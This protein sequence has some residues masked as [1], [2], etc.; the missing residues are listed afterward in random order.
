[1]SRGSRLAG[2]GRNPQQTA[3]GGNGP[4]SRGNPVFPPCPAH[5]REDEVGHTPEK[6]RTRSV[7]LVFRREFFLDPE[8][9][10]GTAVPLWG[11]ASVCRHLSPRTRE[12]GGYGRPAWKGSA[13][14]C[15]PQPRE[16]VSIPHERAQQGLLPEPGPLF[17]QSRIA[18]D[19]DPRCANLV[20]ARQPMHS[21]RMSLAFSF[22]WKNA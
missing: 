22:P 13:P 18:F 1:M 19:V 2:V 4:S 14:I 9:S 8:P 10:R 16:Q 15:R 7:P 17:P 6:K 5:L 21:H 12:G 20:A 3:P 11:G